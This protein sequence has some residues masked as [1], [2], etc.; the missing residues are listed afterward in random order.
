MI[1]CAAPER[2]LRRRIPPAGSLCSFQMIPSS[3]EE[4]HALS[5]FRD[6]TAGLGV[7]ELSARYF[8]APKSIQRILTLGRRGLLEP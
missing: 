7:D 1:L 8:L 4:H 5:I 6:Y 2:R 3:L